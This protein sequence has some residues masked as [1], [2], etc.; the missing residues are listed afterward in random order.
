QLKVQSMSGVT[1]YHFRL[2]IG[3]TLVMEKYQTSA[4]WKIGTNLQNNTTYTWDCQAQNTNGWGPY[5]SPAWSFTV[6]TKGGKGDLA[7]PR[8]IQQDIEE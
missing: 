3:N 5:F 6:K 1:Q 8:T 2:F 7:D 4:T